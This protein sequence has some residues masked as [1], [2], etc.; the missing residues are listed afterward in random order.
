MVQNMGHLHTVCVHTI[1]VKLGKEEGGHRARNGKSKGGGDREG[2]KEGGRDGR[3][4]R[5]RERERMQKF[6]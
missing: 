6:G 2:G 1:R 4:E 3:R 5:G